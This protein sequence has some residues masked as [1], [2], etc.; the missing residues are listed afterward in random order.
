[1]KTVAAIIAWLLVAGY[2][3][4][5]LFYFAEVWG[6]LGF[7]GA[8]FTTP[9]S[10]IAYVGIC[11]FSSVGGFILHGIILTVTYLL[12]NYAEEA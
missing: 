7:F 4:M 5:S 9:L 6:G 3:V 12:W 10:T 8:L 2:W 11:L 1:M